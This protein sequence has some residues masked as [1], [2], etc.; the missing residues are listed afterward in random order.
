LIK[1]ALVLVLDPLAVLLTVRGIKGS[2][3]VDG[4]TR[5]YHSFRK[6]PLFHVRHPIVALLRL[7][8]ARRWGLM[9]CISL[10][11]SRLFLRCLQLSGVFI[12]IPFVSNYAF[13]IMTAAYVIHIS[14]STIVKK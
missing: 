1:L 7:P 11:Y 4:A 14:S 6:P 10:P 13:W 3:L 12:E 9:T 5:C 8:V 2:G